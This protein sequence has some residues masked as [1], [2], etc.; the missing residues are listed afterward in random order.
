MHKCM[1]TEK[2]RKNLRGNPGQRSQ[3]NGT[4]QHSMTQL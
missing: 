1:K 4:H 2:E 3:K